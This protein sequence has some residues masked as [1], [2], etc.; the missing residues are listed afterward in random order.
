MRPVRHGCARPAARLD[1]TRSAMRETPTGRR[2]DPGNRR[3]I[4][5]GPATHRAATDGA[6]TT[7]LLVIADER[8]N[9]WYVYGPD[10]PFRFLSTRTR[11]RQSRQPKH[12]RSGAAARAWWSTTAT[13]ARITTRHRSGPPARTAREPA[14]PT[15][16]ASGSAES[17]TRRAPHQPDKGLACLAFT[18]RRPSCGPLGSWRHI[19]A[20]A[21]SRPGP[22]LR[23]SWAGRLP[24]SST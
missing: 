22:P 11:R 15:S 16:L 7:D 21:G 5:P 17:A 13:T 3:A 10:S 1:W 19:R 18:E 9:R 6:S 2:S 8:T 20:A 12:G 23:P 24:P 4:A 14:R